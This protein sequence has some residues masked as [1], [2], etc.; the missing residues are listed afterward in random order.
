MVPITLVPVFMHP[1]S[2]EGVS[3]TDLRVMWQ[4]PPPKDA[5]GMIVEY[6]LYQNVRL[7][8]HIDPFGPQFIWT[9]S[10]LLVKYFC[11][12]LI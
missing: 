6:K 9:V 7:D 1:P 3:S 4:S 8:S 2:V 12:V 5:K 10:I 11:N